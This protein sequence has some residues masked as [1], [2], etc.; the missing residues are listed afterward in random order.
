MFAACGRHKIPKDVLGR[1]VGV[2]SV[3]ILKVTDLREWKVQDWGGRGREKARRPGFGSH[4]GQESAAG[5]GLL[6]RGRVGW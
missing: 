2:L 4:S 1:G 6:N 5:E 3:W